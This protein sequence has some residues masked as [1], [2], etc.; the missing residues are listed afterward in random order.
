VIEHACAD[1]IGEATV[2]A[3]ARAAANMPT[4]KSSLSLTAN[5]RP[6]SFRDEVVHNK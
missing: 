6:F 4:S 5:S 1:A 2:P 3:A